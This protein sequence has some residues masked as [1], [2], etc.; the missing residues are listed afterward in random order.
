MEAASDDIDSSHVW[1]PLCPSTG[2]GLGCERPDMTEP[3]LWQPQNVDHP[4]NVHRRLLTL[5]N[6]VN[7]TKDVLRY[8]QQQVLIEQGLNHSTQQPS[9]YSYVPASASSSDF[10]EEH[11]MS[12]TDMLMSNSLV[13]QYG[14]LSGSASSSFN[15]SEEKIANLGHSNFPSLDDLHTNLSSISSNSSNPGYDSVPGIEFTPWVPVPLQPAGLPSTP[16]LSPTFN[17]T[18][19]GATYSFSSQPRPPTP[20][21]PL[22]E[23]KPKDLQ[24]E[25]DQSTTQPGNLPKRA[26]TISIAD[27]KSKQPIYSKWSAQEDDLLRTAV[28]QHGTRSW[29]EV[30]KQLPDRSALQCS[31]KWSLLTSDIHKGNWSPEED[32]ILSN[33][34]EEWTEKR[35]GSQSSENS[36]SK[37]RGM[38]IPWHDIA[39]LL[40]R[41]RTG[42]QCQ[43]R[44]C[45]SLDKSIRKGK[46]SPEEDDLLM[47]GIRAHGYMWYKIANLVHNRTQRQCRTRWIQIKAMLQDTGRQRRLHSPRSAELVD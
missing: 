13:P 42:V 44:W 40:P 8:L 10:R 26:Q 16:P 21:S 36:V 5:K 14:S 19:G 18:Q 39:S 33:A 47:E 45:E 20:V 1:Q 43:A 25:Q 28:S 38:D 46:W 35:S 32:R 3:D 12:T 34:V 17:Y 15:T 31:N 11:P 2:L 30:A 27:Q 41:K 6:Q 37:Y 4:I 24:S 7:Y 9:R 23:Q 22:S 29:S